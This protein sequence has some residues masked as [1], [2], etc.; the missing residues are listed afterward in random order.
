M[1]FDLDQAEAEA[2]NEWYGGE[3]PSDVLEAIAVKQS[4]SKGVE[5][6]E[7]Q[8]LCDLTPSMDSNSRAVFLFEQLINR[9][10]EL[11]KISK[12]KLR[13]AQKNAATDCGN[14]LR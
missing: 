5:V 9:A 4:K 2:I 1:Y 13:A 7:E 11:Q 14:N 12:A 3:A 6:D 8:Y 10:A